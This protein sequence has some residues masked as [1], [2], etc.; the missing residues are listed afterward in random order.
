MA[1]VLINL[2]ATAAPGEIVTIRLMIRHPMETGFRTGP[3][4][5]RVPRDILREVRAEVDGAVV[6]AAELFPAV[7]AN[8]P[9][10]FTLR[11]EGRTE[12]TLVW[13]LWDGSEERAVR[14]IEA[15]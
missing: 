4:G 6:F 12:L 1:D 5:R 8:P 2:P 11:V 7:A 14:V 9:F 13:T 15:A 10:A 3:D